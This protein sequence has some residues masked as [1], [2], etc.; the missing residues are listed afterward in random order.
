MKKLITYATLGIA[1]MFGK[2]ADAAQGSLEVMA[3]ESQ[4]TTDL[5]AYDSLGKQFGFIFRNRNTV[6]Y[7]SGNSSFSLVDL[8]YSLGKGIDLIT[9]SQFIDGNDVDQRFGAKYFN[10]HGDF[11]IFALGTFGFNKENNFE[12]DVVFQYNPQIG[13]IPLRSSLEILTNV[14]DDGNNFTH[15]RVRLGVGKNDYSGGLALD[16]AQIG[17]EFD[18]SYV[19]GLYLKKD[20]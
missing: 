20:F 12:A 19:I 16:C 5:I 4:A 6:D 15:E 1:L 14:G 2:N 11:S 17:K 13:R 18:S 10:S 9:E 3:G 8:T 7:E